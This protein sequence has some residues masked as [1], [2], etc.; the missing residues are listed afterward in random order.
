MHKMAQSLHFAAGIQN[1]KCRVLMDNHYGKVDHVHI[2]GQEFPYL[3]RDEEQLMK[4]F[5]DLISGLGGICMKAKRFKVYIEPGMEGF[6]QR[7]LA[8]WK[9][10]ENRKPSPSA[11]YDLILSFPDISWIPK[12]FSPE[13]IRIMQAVKEFKPESVYQLAK[14]LNRAPSNVQKDVTELAE[15]GI[16]ELKKYRKKGQKRECV[17]PEYRWSGFDIA[18]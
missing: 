17:K 3:F 6:T 4:D 5:F 7:F 9:A 1:D 8:E 13:R 10:A 18:V 14:I 16:L 12:I 11:G 2:D 15:L